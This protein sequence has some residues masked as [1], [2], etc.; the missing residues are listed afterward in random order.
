VAGFLRARLDT[1]L[2]RIAFLVVPS[3]VAFLTLGD[4]LVGALFQTGQFTRADSVYVWGILGGSSIGL[5]AS[6]LGRLYSSTYYAL[7]DTRTPLRYAIVRVTLTTVLGIA[8]AIYLPPLLGIPLKWGA[9]GLTTSAGLAAWVE[10]F[11]LRRTLGRRIGRT[12]IP[13]PFALR[14]W[15]AALLGAAAGW[16]IKVLLGVAHPIW[17][18]LAVVAP[19]GLIY[20]GVTSALGVTEARTMIAGLRHRR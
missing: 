17:L 7:R 1:G 3:A 18:A 19:F 4:V 6:T 15:A 16:G 2:R 8:F 14:L 11:L 12:G 20:F 13:L 10:F 5:L 9:V